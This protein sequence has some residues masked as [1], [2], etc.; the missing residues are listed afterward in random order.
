MAPQHSMSGTRNGPK[1]SLTRELRHVL[2]QVRA[3]QRP[4]QIAKPPERD[5]SIDDLSEG[6]ALE[7]GHV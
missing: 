6:W 3:P 5:P 1:E 7:I 4:A 2:V